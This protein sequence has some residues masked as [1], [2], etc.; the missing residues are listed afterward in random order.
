[1]HACGNN[2][3]VQ[4]NLKFGAAFKVTKNNIR[5]N[6]MHSDNYLTMMKIVLSDMQALLLT[7]KSEYEKTKYLEEEQM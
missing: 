6:F 2:L 5:I 1:M 4:R 7:R 3:D